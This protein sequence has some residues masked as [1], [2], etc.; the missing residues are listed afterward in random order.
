[1]SITPAVRE[2]AARRR[3]RHLALDALAVMGFSALMS[4]GFV[5]VLLA[6]VQFIH[7]GR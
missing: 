3:V 7:L 4:V 2:E 5:L 1:M 6:L